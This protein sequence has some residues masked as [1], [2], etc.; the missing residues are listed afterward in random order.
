MKQPA[1]NLRAVKIVANKVFVL[2]TLLS[3]L[4]REFARRIIVHEA[5]EGE[6]NLQALEVA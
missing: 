1:S 5:E 4:K 6:F 3:N 2:S